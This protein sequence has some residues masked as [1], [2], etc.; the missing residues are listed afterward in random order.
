MRRNSSKKEYRR[1]QREEKLNMDNEKITS[2]A[3]LP[4]LIAARDLLIVEIGR[5]IRELGLNL[6]EPAPPE[7]EP[8]PIVKAFGLANPENKSAFERLLK[9]TVGRL[10]KLSPKELQKRAALLVR[11][12]KLYEQGVPYRDIAR[13]VD[14]PEMTVYHWVRRLKLSAGVDNEPEIGTAADLKTLSPS[15]GWTREEKLIEAK[16]LAAQG[17]KVGAIGRQLGVPYA[18]LHGWLKQSKA[19]RSL[20]RPL[21]PR[22]GKPDNSQA[23]EEARK[24]REQGMTYAAIG[25]QLGFKYQTVHGWLKYGRYGGHARGV[26]VAS[27]ERRAK[28][29]YHGSR[30]ETLAKI[31]ELIAA[32]KKHPEIASELGMNKSSVDRIL[33]NRDGKNPI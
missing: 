11:V 32:G 28:T 20:H 29:R 25:K 3:R 8:A 31:K 18:T 30:A 16:K 10:S 14:Q 4:G 13:K 19:P 21:N 22:T 5:T 9:P 15:A 26:S 33:H 12:R 6:T 27:P 1:D 7:G 23:I 2:I 24:L 17:M